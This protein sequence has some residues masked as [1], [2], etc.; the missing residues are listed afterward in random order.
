MATGEPVSWQRDEPGTSWYEFACA[1]V[2]MKWKTASAKYRRAIAQA[3]TAATPRHAGQRI[4]RASD[5]DLRRALVNWG[6][7][8]KQRASAPEDVE[9]ILRWLA[10]NTREV[11]EL[12]EPA[13]CRQLLTAATSRLDGTRAAPDVGT[14]EPRGVAQR[15]RVRR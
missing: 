11:T 12:A 1:Y 14:Q 6:Y 8:T 9:D 13:L 4:R 10:R 7:N 3:L 15:P 5:Q 2:D